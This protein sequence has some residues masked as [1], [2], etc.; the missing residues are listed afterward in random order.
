MYYIA[1]G[2]YFRVYLLEG[3]LFLEDFALDEIYPIAVD[4]FY[5]YREPWKIRFFRNLGGDV[6][7]IAVDF[8]RQTVIG[9]RVNSED[10]TPSRPRLGIAT[11]SLKPED[12]D[13]VALNSLF[14]DLKVNAN[15]LLV[16]QVGEETPASR[17]GIRVNDIILEFGNETLM[18]SGDLIRK[19]Y[20]VDA[21]HEVVVKILRNDRVIY[22]GLSF[23]Q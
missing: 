23:C 17:A 16:T 8:Q 6:D 9:K 3:K 12:M 1:P 22:M 14:F 7:I 13:K 18:Y 21:R 15:A 19:L 2:S 20:S 4:Q 5:D 10:E 11:R